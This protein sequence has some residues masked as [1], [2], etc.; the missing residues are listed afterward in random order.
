MTTGETQRKG[1]K[2]AVTFEQLR[3]F[4]TV[5]LHGRVS[6]AAAALGVSQPAV[7]Q[8]LR[9]LEEALGFALLES[10]EGRLVPTEQGERGREIADHVAPAIEQARRRFTDLRVEHVC[11]RVPARFVMNQR[12]IQKSPERFLVHD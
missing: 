5:V 12:R 8:Q 6:L 9:R 1:Y 7:S 11:F 3:V 2:L 4:R 10:R